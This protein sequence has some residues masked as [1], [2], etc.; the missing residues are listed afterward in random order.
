[1]KF[2]RQCVLS[3]IFVLFVSFRMTD[4]DKEDFIRRV[5]AWKENGLDLDKRTCLT[6]N[7]GSDV[8]LDYPQIRWT[9]F[10]IQVFFSTI[11]LT[12]SLYSSGPNNSPPRS[13]GKP[14]ITPLKL[15]QI[16][17][18]IWESCSPGHE[19]SKTTWLFKIWPRFD[20]V[21]TFLKLAIFRGD[22]VD[23]QCSLLSNLAKT[24]NDHIWV[25]FLSNFKKSVSFG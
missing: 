23:Q 25:K 2:T 14:F 4:Q 7:F 12:S 11:C 19:N 13:L 18:L 15:H 6:L 10:Y 16:L 1:M 21:M 17:F 24:S 3:H 9:T 20:Q 22:M 8:V 5:I